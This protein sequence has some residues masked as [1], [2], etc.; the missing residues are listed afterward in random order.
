MKTIF[1]TDS[2]NDKDEFKKISLEVSEAI[3]DAFT[4]DRAYSGPT[5]QE[6]K[7]IIRQ[8]SILP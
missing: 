4:D 7:E 3:A 5:P 8:D 6:L 2:K 1:L